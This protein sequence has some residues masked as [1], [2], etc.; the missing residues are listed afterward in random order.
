MAAFWTGWLA[1]VIFV[2][3]ALTSNDLSLRL[4]R[5]GW[6]SLHR[7]AHLAALLTLAHWV[8]TAF[9]PFLGWCHVAAL[10]GLEAWRFAKSYGPRRSAAIS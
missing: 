5:R 4:L 2:P 1:F 9:D 3:L 6:K 8:L 10:A 7:F